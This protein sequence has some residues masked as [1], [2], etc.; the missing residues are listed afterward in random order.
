MANLNPYPDILTISSPDK[1]L[2]LCFCPAAGGS[3]TRLQRL[4][5]GMSPVDIFRPHNPAYPLSPLNASCFPM[6]PVSNRISNCELVFE[7]EKFHI[8]PPFGQEPNYLHG[9]GW[10]SPWTVIEHNHHHAIMILEKEASSLSPYAYRAEQSFR[11]QN[12]KLTMGITVTNQGDRPLPFGFGHHPYFPPDSGN[13]GQGA[14]IKGLAVR[15]GYASHHSHRCAP[16][17]G[18]HPWGDPGR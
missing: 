6:V 4:S 7:G 17:M 16:E 14:A 11:L 18:F 5:E 15:P 9:D 2:L 10:T 12:D 13:D 3:V 1:S 8:G